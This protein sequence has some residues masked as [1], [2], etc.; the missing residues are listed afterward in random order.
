M[1]DIDR[2]RRVG[3]AVAKTV[4]DREGRYKFDL[5]EPGREYYV[6]VART[7]EDHKNTRTVT[8]APLDVHEFP[9]IKFEQLDMSVSGVVVDPNGEPVEGVVVSARDRKTGRQLNV[10]FRKRQ[11]SITTDKQGRFT[12]RYLPD[13]PLRLMA[14]IRPDASSKDR[15]IRFPA[16]VDV[17]PG[18]TDV[19]IVLDPKLVR[20]R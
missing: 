20:R 14:Y 12:L 10:Q 15:R 1:R 11:E 16:Y 4:T 5:V 17:E 13:S 2:G 6:R 8:L 7:E 9:V 19:K 3:R 18:Q